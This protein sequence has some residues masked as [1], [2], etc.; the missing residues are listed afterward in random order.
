MVCF[1]E[2]RIYGP[3]KPWLTYWL[4]WSAP[5]GCYR[6]R[7]LPLTGMMSLQ[8]GCKVKTI[9]GQLRTS[10]VH[11]GSFG[12]LPPHPF[13]PPTH[14]PP[15]NSGLKLMY[16]L[17]KKSSKIKQGTTSKVNCILFNR[18][19]SPVLL[20]KSGLVQA[21]ARNFNLKSFNRCFSNY[22][23]VRTWRVF[24]ESVTFNDNQFSLCV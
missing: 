8:P 2:G 1:S 5:I 23:Q 19:L 20:N 10:C 15:S 9:C 18:L 11:L 17:Q 13:P 24:T 6:P 7:I 22:Y 14:P 16:N 12:L 4:L 21:K 3:V